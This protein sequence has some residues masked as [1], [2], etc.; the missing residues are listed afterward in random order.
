VGAPL[1]LILPYLIYKIYPPEI[2]SSEDVSVWATEELE[3]MGKL[4]LKELLMALLAI[5]ALILWIVG[6][7]VV[8]ATTV[9]LIII[10]LMLILGIISHDDFLSHKKAWEI[11]VWFA[12]LVAMADGLNKVGFVTWFAKGSVGFLTGVSP[13]VT[14]M[15]LVAIFYLVHYMFAS[16]TAHTAAVLPVI[17]AAGAAVPGLPVKVFALLLCYSLGLMGVIT[18]YAIG[19][20]PVY[21]G[22]GFISRKDFWTQGLILGIIFLIALIVIGVPWLLAIN[23]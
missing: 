16:I 8:D 23:L 20:G 2:K 13:V 11:L 7:Q 12:T 10:S 19:P 22:S 4:T 15:M 3:K 17:L 1:L 18:P 21:F 6:G 5:F 14:M 9:T